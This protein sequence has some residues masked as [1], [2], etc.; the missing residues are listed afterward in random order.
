MGYEK[1]YWYYRGSGEQIIV[2][3]G[4][5]EIAKKFIV[6]YVRQDVQEECIFQTGGG[7][8]DQS[9]ELTKIRDEDLFK[10]MFQVALT[11]S[12]DEL[13]EINKMRKD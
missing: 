10:A 9:R 5:P 13:D 6:D 1:L 3:K 2:S 11:L 4:L 12:K 8:G 7:S